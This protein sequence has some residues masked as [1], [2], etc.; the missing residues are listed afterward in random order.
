VKAL[1]VEPR[2]EDPCFSRFL[3]KLPGDDYL[4]AILTRAFTCA[5][6]HDPANRRSLPEDFMTLSATLPFEPATLTGGWTL[7]SL[8]DLVD[9]RPA[10]VGGGLSGQG[11]RW[12]GSS[13][14]WGGFE[15]GQQ[16]WDARPAVVTMDDE[17]ED[18]LEDESTYEG[19]EPDAEDFDEEDFDDDF[20]Y[21]FDY[22]EEEDDDLGDDDAHLTEDGEEPEID[23]DESE[24]AD[25]DDEDGPA[26]KEDKEKDKEKG[27]DKDDKEDEF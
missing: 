27:K 16:P 8:P 7:P 4:E 3:D 10:G 5:V 14:T 23:V 12:G 6:P 26:S 19:A 11:E 22:E 20:D 21:D 13:E 2:I 1:Q 15:R 18:D 24:L 25:L 9:N 17:D